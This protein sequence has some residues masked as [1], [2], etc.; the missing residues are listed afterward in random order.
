MAKA[1]KRVAGSWTYVPEA[2]RSLPPEQQTVF[3]LSPLTGAERE[4]VVDELNQRAIMPDGSIRIISRTRSIARDLVL[5]HCDRIERFPSD[6]PK[7]WPKEP[8]ARQA[9]L[10]AMDDDLVFEVGNEVYNRSALGPETVRSGE[11]PG[12]RQIVGE[13]SAPA[14]TSS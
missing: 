9:Y 10:E 2:D 5:S 3:T 7:G 1:K 14:P 12:D 11:P 6:A 8:D 4:R 13:S